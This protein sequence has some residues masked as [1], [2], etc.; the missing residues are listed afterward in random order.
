MKKIL[1]VLAM[2]VF[3]VLCVPYVKANPEKSS[4]HPISKK[5]TQCLNQGSTTLEISLCYETA[6]KEWDTALNIIYQKLL[7]EIQ[8]P[9]LKEALKEIQRQ[10]IKNRN[11]EFEFFQKLYTQTGGTISMINTAASRAK[12]VKDRVSEL[13]DI[14]NSA[15]HMEGL[16]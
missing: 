8:D 16:E 10:W 6:E 7:S 2:V 11:K 5:L 15:Y 9:A 1:K 12:I 14:Y 4:L 13:T 3:C